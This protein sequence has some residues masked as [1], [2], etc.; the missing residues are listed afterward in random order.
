ME[1][2]A[3]YLSSPEA[4]AFLN[5][6]ETTLSRLAR[7]SYPPI[8]LPREKLGGS[9][10][11]RRDDL[12]FVRDRW[13]SLLPRRG[14]SAVNDTVKTDSPWQAVMNAQFA[15]EEPDAIDRSLMTMAA[16]FADGA[17]NAVEIDSARVH[18]LDRIATA[19]ESLC[20]Y[21]SS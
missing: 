4:A 6:S 14:R 18:H 13:G 20:D 16:A 7:G 8:K 5:I 21:V 19:L 15:A 9:Q 1:A 2:G 3:E 11:Y 10:I 17:M 12:E